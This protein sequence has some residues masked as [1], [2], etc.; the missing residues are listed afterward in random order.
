MYLDSYFFKTQVLKGFAYRF[1]FQISG[2][3]DF[4]LD[5]SLPKS[6]NPFGK[7]TNCIEVPLVDDP[8]VDL[9]RMPSYSSAD[10][11]KLLPQSILNV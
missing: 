4:V 1:Y 3:N 7:T 2:S 5:D 10:M 8:S 6:V 11:P 9:Y